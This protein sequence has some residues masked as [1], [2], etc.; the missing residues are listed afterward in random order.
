MPSGVCREC[1]CTDQQACLDDEF[2]AC[3]WVE[4]DLCSHCQMGL[5]CDHAGAEEAALIEEMEGLG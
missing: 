3:W 4:P 1:G 2:G 5:D